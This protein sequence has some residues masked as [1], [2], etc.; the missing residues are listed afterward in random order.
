MTLPTWIGIAICIS[1]SAMLSGL[2]LAFF[3]ISKLELKIEVAKNNKHARRVLSLREDANFVLVTILW[4]NVAVNVLLALLSGSVLTG[5]LAFL[6]STVII[7]IFGEIIPQAYFSRHA[8]RF[9]SMFSPGLRFYQIVLF[10]V[11]KPTA[12]VLDRWLGPEAITYF[13]EKDIRQLIKLHMDSSKSDIEK[14]EGQGALNFLALDDVPLSDEGEPI[15]PR[16]IVQLNFQNNRPVFPEINPSTSDVFL[17]RIHISGKKWIVLV[18]PENEP[19][20]VIDSDEFICDALFKSD[21]FNP[22][23]HCHRPIIARN[24][25]TTIGDVIS[26]LRV[27]PGYSQDDVIDQDVILLWGE[28][29]RVITGADVLGRLLRGIVRSTGTGSA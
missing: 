19:K 18:D 12:L 23:W 10:P 4:A 27:K 9:G 2:N 15:H 1:Q 25:R 11:A 16:G 29:K 7:T 6:F 22:Y 13:R 28:N 14:V 8:L 26:L 5:V 3:T 24:G 21:R 20:F 17:R